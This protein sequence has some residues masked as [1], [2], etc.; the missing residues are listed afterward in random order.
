MAEE[1]NP[2]FS[3]APRKRFV[4]IDL[5]A[6]P[7]TTP[8]NAPFVLYLFAAA[9]DG[10]STLTLKPFGSNVAVPTIPVFQQGKF[11]LIAIN[12]LD[13]VAGITAAY[14]AY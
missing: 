9:V 10:T 13:A 11:D 7:Y 8:N 12:S 4:K 2:S 14:A 6:L 5:A 3:A 1:L